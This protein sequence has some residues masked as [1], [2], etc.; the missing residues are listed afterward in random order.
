M[1]ITL[2][3]EDQKNQEESIDGHTYDEEHWRDMPGVAQYAAPPTLETYDD[4]RPKPPYDN[5]GYDYG[6]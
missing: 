4:H 6:Q 1:L 3:A 5:R 2:L